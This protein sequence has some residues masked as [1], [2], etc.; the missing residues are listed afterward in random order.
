M[1]KL[2]RHLRVEEGGGGSMNKTKDIANKQG[3]TRLLLFTET[4]EGSCNM[5]CKYCFL[6][7][8]GTNKKMS[9]EV[10]HKA[11]DFLNLYTVGKPSLHFLGWN[12]LRTG[13]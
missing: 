3:L 9:V 2:K 6:D 7:K 4:G 8:S 11:I 12:H 5:A 13:I 10:L 1:D